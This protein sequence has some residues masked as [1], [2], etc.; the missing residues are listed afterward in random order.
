[1]NGWEQ[2]QLSN[3]VQALLTEF[4]AEHKIGPAAMFFFMVSFVWGLGKRLGW[5][6][7]GMLGYAMKSW[8]ACDKGLAKQ[9]EG[10]PL[11]GILKP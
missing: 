4:S 5:D 2:T 10:V 7:G 9:T 8:E 1:M 3:K 11:G 6:T